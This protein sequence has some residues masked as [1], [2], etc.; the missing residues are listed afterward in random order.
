[1]D[2]SNGGFQRVQP[3]LEVSLCNKYVRYYSRWNM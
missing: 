3:D 2:L 1:L